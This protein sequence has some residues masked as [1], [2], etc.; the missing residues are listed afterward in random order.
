M[1]HRR[2][3]TR[4]LASRFS[5]S[6]FD[7]LVDFFGFCP[8]GFGGLLP[9]GGAAFVGWV[10]ALPLLSRNQA[11]PEGSHPPGR[12]RILSC[13][14]FIRILSPF[15][16]VLFFSVLRLLHAYPVTVHV[17][18]EAEWNGMECVCSDEL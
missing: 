8:G 1:S 4:L 2:V 11:T 18:I 16:A 7:F 14:P 12:L 3:L 6:D 13:C 15:V 10:V 5:N 17:R 9:L